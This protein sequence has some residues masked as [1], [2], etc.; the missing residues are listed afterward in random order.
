MGSTSI[1]TPET[2]QAPSTAESIQAWV[3]SMPAVF[4]E[5]QRQA[6]L[7]AAQQ[8]S[9]A[10][11]YA[12]PLGEAM[13]SAQDALYPQTS[14]LQEQLATQALQGMSSSMPDWMKQ[15]YQSDFNANLGTNAGSGMGADYMSRGLLQQG[16]D[17]QK[18]YQ[19]L[20]LSVA[21]RQPLSQA[22]TPGYSNYAS[23]F[24]PQS[25][26]N[27]NSQNYG[28]YSNAYANMYGTNQQAQASNNSMWSSI[29][30]GGLGG[31]GTAAG[32]IWSARRYKTNIKLWA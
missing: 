31:A 9:L 21:G 3:D 24:T 19:N 6:P 5:Q 20:G 30:G 10:Q 13:K 18:Y 25:V 12:Q 32:G 11:Q 26:M 27:Y 15:Q 7:E 8:V 29:I 28:N 17:W 22:S 23:S 14:K 4:A 2:P 16:Q 1:S